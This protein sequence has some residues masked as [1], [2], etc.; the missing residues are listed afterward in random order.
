MNLLIVPATF[1]KDSFPLPK[2][3]RYTVFR[4]ANKQ[5]HVFKRNPK[6]RGIARHCNYFGDLL[7]ALSFSLPCGLRYGEREET[8]LVVQKSTEKFGQD[9][10]D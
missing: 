9:T 6:A 2:K 4:E 10:V 5:K 7:L 1:T 8:K 3:L